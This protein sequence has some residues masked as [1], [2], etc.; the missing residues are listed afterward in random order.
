[1]N[2]FTCINSQCGCNNSVINLITIIEVYENTKTKNRI[3]FL[4]S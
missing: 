2:N 4:H 1:M 3:V